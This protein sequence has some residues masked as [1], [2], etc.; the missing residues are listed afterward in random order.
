MLA[1]PWSESA[2]LAAT[3]GLLVALVALGLALRPA[4][5][6]IGVA[7]LAAYLLNPFVHLF[8]RWMRLGRAGAA[9]LAYFLFLLLLVNVPAWLGALVVNQFDA[10]L[11]LIGG[12]IGE[13]ALW[14]ARPIVVAGRRFDPAPLLAQLEEGAAR[15]WQ[16]IPDGSLAFLSSVT[17]SLL[18]TVVALVL[19]YYLL[20]DGPA[21]KN[22]MVRQAPAA[23]QR[24]FARLLD[25]VDLIWSRFLRVQVLMFAALTLGILLGSLL[26]VWIWQS[27]VLGRSPLV[28]ILGLLLVYTLLQQLDNLWLRPHF[29]GRSLQ[30]HPGVVFVGL[31]AGLLVGGV[32]GVLFAVPFIASARAIGAYLQERLEDSPTPPA[33]LPWPREPAVLAEPLTAVLSEAHES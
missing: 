23:E 6:A 28:L 7:A 13:L 19:I 2:R 33:A 16:A 1:S 18:W 14:L 15:V 27:G 21:L 8:M 12:W 3:V 32:L 9:R 4:A 11:V 25:D 31:I 10:L 24:A 17:A 30:L 22:W 5:P 26:V 29:L 20:K